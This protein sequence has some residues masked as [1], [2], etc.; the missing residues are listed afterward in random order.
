MLL[1]YIKIALRNLA[2]QKL[3]SLIN[4]LG[5]SIGLACFCLFLLF[6][7][8]EFSFDRFHRNASQI[9]RVIEWGQTSN[10]TDT[11]RS[12]NS[13]LPLGPAMKKDFPDVSDF[14][15]VRSPRDYYVRV[16]GNTTRQ[17]VSYADPDFFNVFSFPLLSGNPANVLQNPRGIVITR[18]RALQLFGETAV[19]GR[20]VEIKIE[21]KFEPFIIKGVAENPASNSSIQ[22]DVLLSFDY[23]I[24]H[25]DKGDLDNWHRTN[26]DETY[27]LLNPGSRLM[28][29]SVKLAQFRYKYVGQEE[30]RMKKMPKSKWR[31][32]YTVGYSLQPLLRMHTDT[33]TDGNARPMDPKNIWILVSIA[34]AVLLIACINFTT[35]SIGRSAGR[36]KEVGVRKVIGARR[37]LLIYQ[38]LSESLLLSIFAAFLGLILA[39][40]LLPFFNQLSGRQLVFSFSQFPEMGWLLTALVLA[41]GILAGSYPALLLSGFNAVEVLKNKIKLGGSNFFTRSLV[42]IQFVISFGLIVSTIIILQQVAF[43]R[44]KD[45]GFKKENVVVVNANDLDTKLIFPLFKQSL[46]SNTAILGVSASEMGLGEGSGYMNTHFDWEGKSKNVIVYPVEADFLKVLG[47]QIIAGRGF[48]PVLVS[49]TNNSIIVNEALLNDFGIPLEKAVGMQIVPAVKYDSVPKLIIGVARDFNFSPL[50]SKVVPQIFILPSRLN[51]SKFFVR[52]KAGDPSKTIASLKK[53]WKN[54]VTDIPF[55]YSFLDEDVDRFYKSEERWS[56]IVGWAGGISIFLACLGLFGLAAL[57]AV[58][59]TKEVGIRKV[60]GASTSTIVALL[61]GDFLKE[62]LLALLIATPIAWYLMDRWLEDYAYRI[63]IGIWIFAIT[64]IL[65]LLIAFLTI[66]IQALRAAVAN[67]IKS[68]RLE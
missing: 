17:R 4:I 39:K 3:L 1:H 46:A 18:D 41:V 20:T 2:K 36:A 44:S 28:Y 16:D 27:V 23:I 45:L 13:Y 35:L 12:A 66:G 43:M 24:N 42:G 48:D 65:T 8:N 31:K 30:D 7:V 57:A 6:A 53:F 64:G 68:L 15:R 25:A 37:K 19:V 38:F 34:A 22:F 10:K 40:S 60:M 14:V 50:Q 54:I 56:N 26:G 55:R 29:D 59:R 67:P 5:L 47:M 49:D 61:S 52:I 32:D 58:N 62:V 9:Y 51:P 33:S 11:R 21:D 63:H